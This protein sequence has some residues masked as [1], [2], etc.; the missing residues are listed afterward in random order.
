MEKVGL[1]APGSLRLAVL[2]AGRVMRDHLKSK[3]SPSTSVEP[4]PS[5]VTTRPTGADW[6]GPAL[7]TGG[8]LRVEMVTLA[9]A[10]LI[11]PSLT[12]SCRR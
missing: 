9:G 7:A 3:A 8:E 4:L 10:L 2:P 11:L 6:S 1:I 12:M 5:R